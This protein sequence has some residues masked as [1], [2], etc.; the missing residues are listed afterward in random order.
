MWQHH[1]SPLSGH[2]GVARTH[3]LLVPRYYWKNMTD[4]IKSFIRGCLPCLRRK[5][6]RPRQAGLTS[7]MLAPD[8][9]YGWAIDSVGKLPVTRDGNQYVLTMINVFTRWVIAVP[10]PDRSTES[11]TAAL[12]DH[13]IANHG[14]PWVLLSDGEFR[15]EELKAACRKLNIYKVETTRENPNANGHIERFHR[16]MNAALT[17]YSNKY[18]HDWDEH[19]QMIVFAHRCSVHATTGFSPFYLT[20]GHHPQLPL[21]G[22]FRRPAADEPTVDA[23]ADLSAGDL[24]DRLR[25]AYAIVRTNQERAALLNARRR[26]TTRY[27][28][29]YEPNDLVLWWEPKQPPR[30][31]PRGTTTKTPPAPTEYLPNKLLWKWSGPHYIVKKL[32]SNNDNL[33]VMRHSSR[34]RDIVVNVNALWPYTPYEDECMSDPGY[35]PPPADDAGGDSR[36]V[37]DDDLVYQPG[38]MVVVL[39]S[40]PALPFAVAKVLKRFDDDPS[41]PRFTVQWYGNPFATLA[42]FHCPGWIDKKGRIYYSKSREHPSHPP[43]TNTDDVDNNGKPLAISQR[44][45]VMR[46]VELTTQDKISEHVFKDLSGDDRVPW[47]RPTKGNY[48]PDR[49]PQ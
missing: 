15:I 12:R 28:V 3:N 9:R 44:H 31:Q 48:N 13:L 35:A 41:C 25:K 38:D 33:Y 27:E 26:D 14:C 30:R 24:A 23:E 40:D 6:P 18:K 39:L 37:A 20:Y 32:H 42:S 16:Y 17:I 47:Q 1:G 4:D 19:L 46:G 11:F 21:D 2:V 5:T 22:F 29:K 7:P 43:Y 10:I 45:L 8:P 36:F 49:V 34:K